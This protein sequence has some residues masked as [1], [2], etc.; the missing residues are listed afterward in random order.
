MNKKLITV[1]YIFPLLFANW[2]IAECGGEHTG[3]ES[4]TPIKK[5]RVNSLVT[6]VPNDGNIKGLVITSCGQ[7]NFGY[8]GKKGCSLTIKIDKTIYQVEGTGIHDH[9]NAHGNEGF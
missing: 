9:G 4:I 8:K 3:V 5:E 1:L 7:C 2:A 6:A